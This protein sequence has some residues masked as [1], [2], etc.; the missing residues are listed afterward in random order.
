MGNNKSIIEDSHL[1]LVE[2]TYSNALGGEIYLKRVAD[3]S[4]E[5][6]I[7]CKKVLSIPVDFDKRTSFNHPNLM[8]THGYS[9]RFL[10]A[11]NNF[12]YFEW[13][14]ISLESILKKKMQER[15]PISQKDIC[16]LIKSNFKI[17]NQYLLITKVSWEL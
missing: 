14:P 8:K 9:S 15:N 1:Q 4:L 5:N 2:Q 10:S 3:R 13:S 11:N 7:L 17:E 6:L 16:A 12:A